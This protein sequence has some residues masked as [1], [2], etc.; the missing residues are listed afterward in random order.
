MNRMKQSRPF[1]AEEIGSIL[2]GAVKGFASVEAQGFL[3]N[4]IRLKNIY[5]G[6]KDQTPIVKVADSNLF[7]TR[8]NVD[9]IRLRE[10]DTD[11]IFLSPEELEVTRLFYRRVS[12]KT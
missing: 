12:A 7:R 10:S 2:A 8:A 11:D 1:T 6:L 9:M 5:F 4:K 3:N